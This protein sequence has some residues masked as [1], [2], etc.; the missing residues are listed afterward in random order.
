[1]DGWMNCCY[2]NCSQQSI[3]KK[4]QPTR[5]N[6]QLQVPFKISQ[7]IFRIN[8]NP[9]FNPLTMDI[10]RRVREISGNIIFQP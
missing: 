3:K 5:Q 9:A 6:Q 10:F 7:D 4:Q 1:M 2:I 8:I